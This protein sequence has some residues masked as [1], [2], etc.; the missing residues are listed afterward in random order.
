MR[1]PMTLVLGLR[2]LTAVLQVDNPQHESE[3][4]DITGVRSTK[5]LVKTSSV[6]ASL[7]NRK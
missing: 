1:F 6:H 4:E 3:S 5:N 7:E 2:A